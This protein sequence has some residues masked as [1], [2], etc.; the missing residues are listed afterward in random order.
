MRLHNKSKNLHVPALPDKPSSLIR[1]YFPTL[2]GHPVPPHRKTPTRALQSYDSCFTHQSLKDCGF[3]FHLTCNPKS[4]SQPQA[5]TRQTPWPHIAK[6]ATGPPTSGHAVKPWQTYLNRNHNG[7]YKAKSHPASRP[8]TL[9]Q[10]T[11][12]AFGTKSIFVTKRKKKEEG[13]KR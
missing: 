11:T 10:K 4:T 6:P 12:T 2:I 9:Q 7:L 13:T 1:P 5:P 3:T 8:R